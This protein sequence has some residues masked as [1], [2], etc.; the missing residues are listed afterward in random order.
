MCSTSLQLWVQLVN[1][2]SVILRFINGIFCRFWP[3]G[4]T[5]DV[6]DVDLGNNLLVK[7]FQLAQN[8]ESL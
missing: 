7:R 2:S 3:A 5:T 8:L 6:L 4:P 1:C